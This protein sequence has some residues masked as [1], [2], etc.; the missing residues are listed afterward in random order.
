MPL[1]QHVNHMA[2]TFKRTEW[3]ESCICIKFCVKLKH[4]STE[5]IRMIQKAAAMGNWWLATSSQHTH[6]SITSCAEFFAKH[7]ITQVTQPPYSPDLAPCDFLFFPK[8]KS[9]FKGKRFQTIEEIQKN[10]MGSW[11]QL[12]EL[13]EVPRCLLWRGLRC[14]CSIYNVSYILCL[15]Q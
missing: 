14:H 1:S 8:L 2:I 3:V 11:W 10:V 4:F 7:Q 12:G 5:T 9:F 13:F 15:F 6:S